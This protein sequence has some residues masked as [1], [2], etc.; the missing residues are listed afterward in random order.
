[1]TTHVYEL[2][3]IQEI[4]FLGYRNV[5]GSCIWRV[6]VLMFLEYHH[7]RIVGIDLNKATLSTAVAADFN[8]L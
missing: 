4:Q 6:Q 1:M 2:G 8:A 5:F 7:R 3:S